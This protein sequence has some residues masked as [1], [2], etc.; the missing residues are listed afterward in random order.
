ML[1]EN[2]RNLRNAAALSQE[3]LAQRL[4]VVRQ[5]VS[6]W[7]K[8]LSAPDAEMLTHLADALGTSV[9]ILLSASAVAPASGESAADLGAQLAE[10]NRLFARQQEHRR[11]FW[12]VVCIIVASTSL[13][14]LSFA[15]A[16]FI[17]NWQT[18]R[19]LAAAVGVIG[20]AD[21]PTAVF[22]TRATPQWISL[23][24]IAGIGAAAL[25]GIWRKRGLP[26]QSSPR[27]LCLFIPCA[28]PSPCPGYPAPAP[29]SCGGGTR[30]SRR[31]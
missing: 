18:S 24:L 26:M 6:K 7:E 15:A 17:H 22:V 27:C 4:H 25:F 20:G 12:R 5:T 1:N 14:I 11:I 3:E 8:G 31:G 16:M 2:I 19:E 23:L 10:L 29:S 9:E 30:S 28:A 13:L 21:G